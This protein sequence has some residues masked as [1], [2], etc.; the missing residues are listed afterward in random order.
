MLFVIKLD[1]FSSS[2]LTLPREKWSEIDPVGKGREGGMK[3]MPID[4]GKDKAI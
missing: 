1:L 4:K 2:K 3:K